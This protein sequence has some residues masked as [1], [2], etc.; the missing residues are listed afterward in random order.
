MYNCTYKQETISLKIVHL[1]GYILIARRTVIKQ[2]QLQKFR[3]CK[4]CK[5][6]S[7]SQ[8]SLLELSHSCPG[9]WGSKSA[10]PHTF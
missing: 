2:K 3:I 9:A 4:F 7:P 5:D 10:A 8:K 6:P 1:L